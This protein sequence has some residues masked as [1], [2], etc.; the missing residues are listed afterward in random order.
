M[1]FVSDSLVTS[2]RIRALTMVDNFSRECLAIEVAPSIKGK[3]VVEV[4]ER[5]TACRGAPKSIQLDNGPEFV[6]RALDC[7]AY[8]RGVTLAFSRPGKPV[9][10]AFIESFNGSFRDECLNVNWFLSLDDARDKI[11]TWR[12]DYTSSVPTLP[13]TT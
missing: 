6:S 13:L 7:W 8:E 9:D 3:Q 10:N 5:V 1:D 12:R 2:R 4:L 11:E